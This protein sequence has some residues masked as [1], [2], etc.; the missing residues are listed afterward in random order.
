M[1]V[2]EK[3]IWQDFMNVEC[4]WREDYEDELKELKNYKKKIE[5]YLKLI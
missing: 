4:K 5:K 1:N 2:F 3:G